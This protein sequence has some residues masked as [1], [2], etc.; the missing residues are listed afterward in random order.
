M[1]VE[2]LRNALVDAVTETVNEESSLAVAFSGGIDS[3]LLAQLCNDKGIKVTLLTV[4]FP[5]SPDIEF[6]KVIATRLGLLHKLLELKKEDFHNKQRY[7]SQKLGC[8]NISHIE[9]CIAFFY[10]G[11][12]ARQNGLRLILTANGCDELFC[13][14]D[15]F[16]ST[17]K[18]GDA[19]IMQLIHE[20]IEN[21]ILLMKEVES[22][23]AE[24]GIKTKHPFLSEKFISAALEIS[25]DN[26]IKGCD[27]F[28]RK[29][30]LREV[31]VSIGVPY[32]AAVKPKKALQYGSLIHKNFRD[33]RNVKSAHNDS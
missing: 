8:G 13:G 17:Y 18:Y 27:D 1:S 9:N 5:G 16:R 15:R 33:L 23:T 2:S 4:G 21:E 30:I 10:L 22:I 32:E 7:I 14:Y 3:S 29:H 19:R 26:K 12:L 6:S 25:I 20:K 28:I 24:F 31:A 11:L